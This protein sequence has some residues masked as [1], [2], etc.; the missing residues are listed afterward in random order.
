MYLDL[1]PKEDGVWG[2]DDVKTAARSLSG[3]KYVLVDSFV[4]NT[5]ELV[6]NFS[7]YICFKCV[8]IWAF[9]FVTENYFFKYLSIVLVL[10]CRQARCPEIA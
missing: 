5:T 1:V 7:Y 2:G 6:Q 9:Q 10:P 4:Q 8:Q 3:I